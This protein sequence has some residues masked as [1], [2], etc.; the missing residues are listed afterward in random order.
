MRIKRLNMMRFTSSFVIAFLCTLSA[1]A[2]HVIKG[3]VSDVN[4]EPMVGVSVVVKGTT[5]GKITDLNGQYTIKVQPKDILTFF[6]V[7]MATQEIKVGNQQVINVTL[8]DDVAA[9]DEVVV[10]GY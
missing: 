1:F 5:T 4:G 3:T 6:C 10:V 7:G 8:K 9:V 2:Q